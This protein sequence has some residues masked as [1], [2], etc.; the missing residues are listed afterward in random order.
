MPE[1]GGWLQNQI[2]KWIFSWNPWFIA[3]CLLL[4]VMGVLGWSSLFSEEN[5]VPFLELLSCGACSSTFC[6]SDWL[7]N[8]SWKTLLCKILSSEPAETMWF[9]V[10]LCSSNTSHCCFCAGNDSRPE[11]ITWGTP[12]GLAGHF[13]SSCLEISHPCSSS[14]C[15]SLHFSQHGLSLLLLSFTLQVL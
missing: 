3:G 13:H 15:I 5:W 2:T 9:F 6:L 10:C 12:G 14:S 11:S 7:M 1:C 4:S 8:R